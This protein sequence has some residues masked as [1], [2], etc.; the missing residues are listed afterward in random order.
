M[1]AAPWV[2][3]WLNGSHTLPQGGGVAD[4]HMMGGRGVRKGVWQTGG[5]IKP[6]CH[7][8]CPFVVVSEQ[9]LQKVY[10]SNRYI[11]RWYIQICTYIIIMCVYS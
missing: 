1:A 7:R 10:K 2:G 4:N 6:E 3:V 8:A 5:Q 9:K 11:S